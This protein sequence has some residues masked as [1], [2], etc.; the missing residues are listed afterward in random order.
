MLLPEE[1]DLPEDE[2]LD[3][4]CNV[5]RLCFY[6]DPVDAK[7]AAVIHWLIDLQQRH[8]EL[9]RH[10]IAGFDPQVLSQ[11]YQV[12]ARELLQLNSEWKGGLA[13]GDAVQVIGSHFPIL[14]LD[15]NRIDPIQDH[16]LKEEFLGSVDNYMAENNVSWE[17]AA[18]FVIASMHVG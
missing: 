1:Q 12:V 7:I 17:E 11:S 13:D 16:Y 8:G 18:Q 10:G 14:D 4:D 3:K 9:L 2:D 15:W 6:E 5:Q